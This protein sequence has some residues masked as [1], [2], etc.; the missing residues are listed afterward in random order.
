MQY[1][2][3]HQQKGSSLWET[4]GVI[5][6]IT[7]MGGS[8]FS[9]YNKAFSKAKD[10]SLSYDFQTEE[11]TDIILGPYKYESIFPEKD[12][13]SYV[14]IGEQCGKSVSCRHSFCGEITLN[15]RKEVFI[16]LKDINHCIRELA[17]KY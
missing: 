11:K 17:K 5:F 6:I 7:L 9:L 2:S 1:N 8:A 16:I 10:L 12:K 14:F 15:T 4:I 3:I 13:G